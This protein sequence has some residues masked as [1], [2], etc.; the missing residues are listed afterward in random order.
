MATSSSP[1]ATATPASSN[2]MPTATVSA[3][4]APLAKAPAS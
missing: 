4:G 2:M 3:N 1:M